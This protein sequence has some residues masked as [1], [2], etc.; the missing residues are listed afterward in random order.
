MS[1]LLETIRVAIQA[2]NE[3]PAAIA[4]GAGVAKSQLSRMLSGERGL[5]VDTLERLADYLGLELV[6]RAKRGRKGR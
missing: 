5:S 3:T 6:I 4:R 2:S 1:R